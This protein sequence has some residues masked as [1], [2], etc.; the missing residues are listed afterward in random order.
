MA[1]K[2]LRDISLISLC[3]LIL[4][5]LVWFPHLVGF[6]N[7]FGLNFS[8]GFNTVYRNFDGLN[9]IVIAKTFYNPS[10]ISDIPFALPASYYAA[11]FPGY[12]FL[13]LI[14]AP[15]LGFLKSMLFVSLISTI[16][17]IIA[18]Y[19]LVRDFKL[20]PNPLLLSL[21]F[22]ILPARWLT[23]HSVGS[24]EPTF[25]L[26]TI[27]TIYF[28][29]KY[30][31]FPCVMAGSG[32]EKQSK[33][34]W[35]AA[36]AG[37]ATQLT[38]P[39]GILLFIALVLYVKYHAFI[40]LKT[41]GLTY[42]IKDKLS[43]FPLLLMPLGLLGVFWIYAVQY[44]DFFAYFHSGN[45]I[46]LTF[47]PYQVFNK[48]QFWVGD[49]WLEDIIYIFILGFLAAMLLLK[50]KLYLM[51]VFVFVYLGATTLVVHRDISRYLLPIVPFVLVAFQKVL[52]SKDFRIVLIIVALAIYLY[53][54][55]FLLQNTAPVPNLEF[56]N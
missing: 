36:L 56:Y 51:A 14:F 50:E 33:F 32:A 26:F 45:N 38:R 48:F 9:Y 34:I 10:S 52:V 2:T 27:L 41:H 37:L 12:P 22:L 54:Q 35:L 21:I 18:F 6:N 11:H 25:I 30:E 55:N 5:L 42:V 44:N 13:I 3:T 53:S 49:I 1:T 40:E 4:T 46:H 47:P 7:F 19:F 29:M 28:F 24:A 39:P 20:T 15:L 17:A 16:G 23:V 8:G 31:G 43:Y